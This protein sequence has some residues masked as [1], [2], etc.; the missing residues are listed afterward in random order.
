MWRCRICAANNRRGTRPFEWQML[1]PQF[2]I[3]FVRLTDRVLARISSLSRN[4]GKPYGNR[5]TCRVNF[6]ILPGE[7]RLPQAPWVL[8]AHEPRSSR[9]E[10]AHY[11]SS[12]RSEP[13]HIGCYDSGVQNANGF[14][15]NSLLHRMEERA[16]QRRRVVIGFP[17]Y[18]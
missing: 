6:A 14:S 11:L 15:G 8:S 16:Q 12:K 13:A 4:Q 17:S 3:D 5:E 9:C 18:S 2:L 10:S 1:L 7:P